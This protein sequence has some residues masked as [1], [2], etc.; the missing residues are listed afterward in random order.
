MVKCVVLEIDV[1][2]YTTADQA[3]A[4]SCDWQKNEVD[5]LVRMSINIILGEAHKGQ[6]KAFV[7]TGSNTDG[8]NRDLYVLAMESLGYKLSSRNGSSFWWE[9]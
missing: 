8:I 4:V 1:T 6:R 9:W 2:G 5:K 7:C 3:L